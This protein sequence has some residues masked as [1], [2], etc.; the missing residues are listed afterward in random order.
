MGLIANNPKHQAGALGSDESDKIA[1]FIQLCDT[2]DLPIVSLCDTPGIMV[3]TEAE[4][5]AL[6]RHASRVF[7]NAAN[8]TV[9][10]FTIVLRKAYGL[11]AMAMGGGSFHQG[12]FFSVS[13]PTGEFGSMGFEGQI[14]LGYRAEL[15]A[16]EDEQ[17]RQARF[18]ELV[19]GLY[20]H[21]KA[22]NVAPF[23][24]IDAVIDPAES[25]HWIMRGLR[26]FPPPP[27]RT[28]RKRANVDTW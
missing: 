6:V 9:P 22:L 3:G 23:L 8:I 25:R 16:I 21:G 14:R 24:S 7:V 10:F 15:A 26:S 13:W 27:P 28:G 12:S 1:R 2:F 20:A 4:R 5:T 18:Q 17:A 19:D 11:G